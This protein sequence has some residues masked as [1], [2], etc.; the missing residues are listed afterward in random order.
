M[1]ELRKVWLK[2][3]KVEEYGGKGKSICQ[4][5][6]RRDKCPWKA[7]ATR[8]TELEN[9]TFQI[10]NPE[11]NHPPTLPEATLTHRKKSSNR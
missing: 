2:C 7:V 10:D 1:Q 5:S 4:T 11:H 8:D 6:S 9:W 3:D